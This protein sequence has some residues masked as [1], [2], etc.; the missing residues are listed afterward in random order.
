MKRPALA[1]V[2][3]I[4][5]SFAS[6]AEFRF[7]SGLGFTG[8]E[9]D[10]RVRTLT[11]DF[12]VASSST[13]EERDELAVFGRWYFDGLSDERGPLAQAAFVDR[14]SSVGLAYS[15]AESSARGQFFTV[16]SGAPADFDFGDFDTDTLAL[17]LRYVQKDS[18]WFGLAALDY[19]EFS[20]PVS[21]DATA[22]SLGV[23]K[24]LFDTTALTVSISRPDIDES[25]PTEYGIAFTHLGSLIGQWQ[26]AADLGYFRLDGDGGLSTDLWST[27][28]R[29][30]PMRQLE[31]GVG[32]DFIGDNDFFLSRNRY[33]GF[34]SWF[35]TPSVQVAARYWSEDSDGLSIPLIDGTRSESTFDRSGYS[36]ALNIRF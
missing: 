26:Y 33:E 4:P 10:T 9:L 8:S 24:Y 30:Y 7:E 22:L 1:A 11:P 20:G 34:A 21:S 18:G 31:F 5:L 15:R 2:L 16:G 27:A 23:G 32:I 6:A 28:L 3:L 36:V 12:I 35:V 17:D 25:D 19:R 14:A 13:E 29:L